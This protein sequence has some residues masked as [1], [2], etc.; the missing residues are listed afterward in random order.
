MRILIVN[1]ATMNMGVYVSL[2][3]PDFSFVSIYLEMG[4]L[5]DRI[6]LVLIF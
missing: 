1:S 2:Q 4:L 6:V 5:D 3:D